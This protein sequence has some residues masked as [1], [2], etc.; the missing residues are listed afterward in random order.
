M[1]VLQLGAKQTPRDPFVGLDG[2]RLIKRGPKTSVAQGLYSTCEVPSYGSVQGFEFAPANS[3]LAFFNQIIQALSGFDKYQ[4]SISLL[5]F[6]TSLRR[7]INADNV[8]KI[9][10]LTAGIQRF[11]DRDDTVLTG[12]DMHLLDGLIDLRSL[13][14]QAEI[15]RT[16]YKNK[17]MSLPYSKDEACTLP[18]SIYGKLASIKNALVFPGRTPVREMRDFFKSCDEQSYLESLNSS[19]ATRSIKALG[20]LVY[21]DSKMAAAGFFD[22]EVPF[23]HFLD[24]EYTRKKCIPIDFKREVGILRLSLA[25]EGEQNSALLP[26]SKLLTDVQKLYPEGID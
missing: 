16:R 24:L 2:F 19:V 8:S 6:S 22:K 13:L 9:A 12:A 21:V 7:A 23:A 18:L 5:S 11:I 25:H 10:D 20:W 3:K 15:D 1:S 4:D 14:P 26:L 17:S